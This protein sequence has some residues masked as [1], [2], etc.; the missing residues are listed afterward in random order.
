MGPELCNRC[1]VV[2][3]DPLVRWTVVRSL[4]TRCVDARS[5]ESGELA[6]VLLREWPVDFL[7][8]ESHLPGMD[9]V[10]LAKRCQNLNCRPS[11]ILL[12]NGQPPLPPRELHRIG[13]IGVIEKPFILDPLARLL[14]GV[15]QK[16]RM[17]KG[18]PVT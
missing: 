18:C 8:A 12:T 5:I 15:A 16:R 1:L 6:I 17:K 2:D 13:V 14:A 11:T 9:G 10:E 7:I 4:Q 3:G